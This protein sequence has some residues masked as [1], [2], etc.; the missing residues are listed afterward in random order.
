MKRFLNM[1][2]AVDIGDSQRAVSRGVDERR[3]VRGDA[4]KRKTPQQLEIVLNNQSV[5]IPL[6]FLL[7]EDSCKLRRGVACLVI[8]H[9]VA[10]YQG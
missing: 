9:E 6:K 2:K 7:T 8:C 3:E 4:G 10:R 1:R 5:W